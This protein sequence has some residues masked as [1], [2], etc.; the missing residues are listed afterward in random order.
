MPDRNFFFYLA[1][2]RWLEPPRGKR[3]AAFCHGCGRA[4]AVW[5][6]DRGGASWE[7]GAAFCGRCGRWHRNGAE[8]GKK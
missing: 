7:G 4:I 8:E 2:R 6:F 5:E 3:P 1:E